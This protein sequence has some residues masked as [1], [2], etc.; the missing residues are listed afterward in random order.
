VLAGTEA[1]ACFGEADELAGEEERRATPAAGGYGS[2]GMGSRGVAVACGERVLGEC[3]VDRR[4][5]HGGVGGDAAALTA[6]RAASGVR[7][8]LLGTYRL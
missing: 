4:E 8:R 3:E 7:R 6:E 5:G 1:A 2:V